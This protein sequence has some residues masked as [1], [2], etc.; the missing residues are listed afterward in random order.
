MY[1]LILG[2]VDVIDWRNLSFLQEAQTAAALTDKQIGR[3]RVPILSMAPGI[4]E[5]QKKHL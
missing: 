3:S 4:G 1:L 5:S 2:R